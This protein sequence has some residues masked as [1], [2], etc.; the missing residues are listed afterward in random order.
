[1]SIATG[2]F[3]IKCNSCDKVHNF[4]ASNSDFDDV[5]SDPDN[6]QGTSRT[7]EWGFEFDCDCGNTIEVVYT[8]HEYPEGVQNNPADIEITGGTVIDQYGFDFSGGPGED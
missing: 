3:S 2:N 7:W 6:P 4:P 5:I 8:V 1:M